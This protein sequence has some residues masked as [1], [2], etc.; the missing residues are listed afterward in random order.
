M[1]RTTLPLL[2][3]LLALL[4]A[5]AL[6]QWRPCEVVG[7]DV[8]FETPLPLLSDPPVLAMMAE[9]PFA[10]VAR[11]RAALA[12][13]AEG[14][15]FAQ[16][17][18][19]TARLSLRGVAHVDAVALYPTGVATFGAVVI[20]LAHH[21]LRFASVAGNRAAVAL[22]PSPRVHHAIAPET[23][24][25]AALSLTPGAPFDLRTLLSRGARRI[26][27]PRGVWSF[28]ESPDAAGGA[29][30]QVS[31]A[32][33]DAV[34]LLEA[35]TAPWR[36][37]LWVTETVALLGWTRPPHAPQSFG[38]GTGRGV[39]RTE[40]ERPA[41]TRCPR[42]IPLLAT[43]QRQTRGIGV[44]PP[45]TAFTLG[46]QDPQRTQVTVH[47][48]DVRWEDGVTLAVPTLALAGCTPP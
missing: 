41:T 43:L 25:C 16:V 1:T 47:D 28:Y 17:R 27:A 34:W 31:G 11:A 3:L 42:P 14:T 35:G 5:P 10:E 18:V 9:Y 29:R 12:R 24:D 48:P 21:R 2:P 30:A 38:Y 13:F 37:M 36:R 46:A 32:P 7:R 45:G 26:A 40:A 22:G 33:R 39:W 6:A 4:P 44:I 23:R 20:P 8:T 19:E 15:P